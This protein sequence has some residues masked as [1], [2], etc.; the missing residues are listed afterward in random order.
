MCDSNDV[1]CISV[2]MRFHLKI[3]KSY[4]D[5]A[6]WRFGARYASS[7]ALDYGEGVQWP[8]KLVFCT[9]FFE[10][11]RFFA[12]IPFLVRGCPSFLGGTPFMRVHTR[13]QAHHARLT[14]ARPPT[15]YTP[16][17]E[18]PPRRAK[19]LSRVP[20]ST[21]RYA[22]RSNRQWIE[23]Q[24]D[25]TESRTRGQLAGRVTTTDF[26]TKLVASS[27]LTAKC[28]SIPARVLGRRAC[29]SSQ[30]IL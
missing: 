14:Y 1:Q 18:N 23:N 6:K 29:S 13:A 17:R 30:S 8:R 28:Q 26:G 9:F 24:T 12:R 27:G 22:P 20:H 5:E 10:I 7:S 16:F 21:R 11:L 25:V 3:T 2:L 15:N 4:L 19:R